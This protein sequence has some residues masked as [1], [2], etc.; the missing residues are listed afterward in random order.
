MTAFPRTPEGG[1]SL[2]RFL[3]EAALPEVLAQVVEAGIPGWEPSFQDVSEVGPLA[4]LLKRYGLRMRSFY[5][6]G[7]MHTAAADQTIARMLTI[8][9]AAVQAGAEVA[10]V[11][12]NPIQWGAAE[13]KTDAQLEAQAQALDTLGREFR[14]LGLTLAYHTHDAEMRASAREFHHMLLA[15]DP[16]HVSLC[17]DTHWIYRG[18][19]NSQV[20]LRDITRLYGARI[21]SWCLS[22]RLKPAHRRRCRPSRRIGRAG[23]TPNGSSGRRKRLVAYPASQADPDARQRASVRFLNESGVTVSGRACSVQ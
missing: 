14:A 19:E 8:A 3:W 13:N 7:E 11:N 6:G 18:A 21:R 5:V 15:T 10:V 4:E 12:P 23:S 20:A 2:R 1:G 17:L 22:R 9:R 16:A